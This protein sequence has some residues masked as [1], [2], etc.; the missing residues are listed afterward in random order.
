MHRWW[1][2]IFIYQFLKENPFL[3]GTNTIHDRL[4]MM[5][6][7]IEQTNQPSIRLWQQKNGW[8]LVMPKGPY[9]HVKRSFEVILTPWKRP[10]THD[11]VLVVVVCERGQEQ[12]SRDF[13][14]HGIFSKGI[15]LSS[16]SFTIISGLNMFIGFMVIKCV[17]AYLWGG[18]IFMI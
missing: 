2:W 4:M 14:D 8:R 3:K 10:H 17:T 15:F 1:W 6:N 5:L 16:Q 11:S 7:N 12:K 9:F 13:N 18:L